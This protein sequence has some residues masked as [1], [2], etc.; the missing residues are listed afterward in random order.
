MLLI[1]RILVA[2]LYGQGGPLCHQPSGGPLDMIGLEVREYNDHAVLSPDVVVLEVQMRE[3]LCEVEILDVA[4]P[5]LVQVQ[6]HQPRAPV[7]VLNHF[8]LLVAEVHVRKPLEELIVGLLL[9]SPLL[10]ERIQSQN[11]HPASLLQA[12]HHHTQSARYTWKDPTPTSDPTS[13]AS[14]TGLA[15]PVYH[16]PTT[17]TL[18]FTTRKCDHVKAPLGILKTIAW[19]RRRGFPTCA[20]QRDIMSTL[21]L[22]IFAIPCSVSDLSYLLAEFP[23]GSGLLPL[24]PLALRLA[25]HFNDQGPLDG[26]HKF[27]HLKKL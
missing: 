23:F 19:L 20:V 4:D 9:A 22:G 7:Q 3:V 5:V 21:T 25:A 18:L 1:P 13:N 6:A 27:D 15:L 8:E 12:V 26:R 16:H 2:V 24:L 11:S 14:Q 10:W 17:S